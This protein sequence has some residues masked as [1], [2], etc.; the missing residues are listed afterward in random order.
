MG[1]LLQL[2]HSQPAFLS[3]VGTPPTGNT[4]FAKKAVDVFFPPEAQNDFPVA[5]QVRRFS[6]RSRTMVENGQEYKLKYWATR[7]HRLLRS[8][9]RSWESEL[10]MSQNDLVLS[11]SAVEAVEAVVSEEAVE[12]EEAAG[13][14]EA[15]EVIVLEVSAP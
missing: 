15:V 12:A 6:I 10:L 7:S 14:E 5:M 2:P 1:I 8:L 3:S 11:H 4:A 9:P 13:V